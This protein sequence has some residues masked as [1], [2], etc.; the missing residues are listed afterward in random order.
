MWGDDCREYRPE[1]W[2][3]DEQAAVHAFSQVLDLQLG[4]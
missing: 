1:R 2:L 4:A 3:S